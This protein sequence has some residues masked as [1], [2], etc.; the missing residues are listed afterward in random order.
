MFL[1]H[2]IQLLK[3]K[4]QEKATWKNSGICSLS[5]KTFFKV[6]AVSNPTR[7]SVQLQ[8]LYIRKFIIRYHHKPRVRRNISFVFYHKELVAD[9]ATDLFSWTWNFMNTQSA[10]VLETSET[11]QLSA[12]QDLNSCSFRM[13]E[14][15]CRKQSTHLR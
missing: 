8:Q 14:R 4:A 5:S 9:E 11:N 6:A 15:N 13:F 2:S 7:I 3:A 12:E 1:S 10:A